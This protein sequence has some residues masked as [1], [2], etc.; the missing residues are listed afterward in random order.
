FG[1]EIA[2]LAK[3]DFERSETLAGRF[4]FPESRI[5]ARL[6]VV[7]GLLDVKPQQQNNMGFRLGENFTFTV[8]P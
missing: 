3:T 5:M 4:Q 7:Q 8:R 2:L 6:A 1:Q